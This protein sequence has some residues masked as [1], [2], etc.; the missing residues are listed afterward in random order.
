MDQ[1]EAKHEANLQ[2]RE[3]GRE[4]MIAGLRKSLHAAE[5]EITAWQNATGCETPSD[6]EA[7]A[8]LEA[9][10]LKDRIATLE[11]ELKERSEMCR[12]MTDAA[13]SALKREAEYRSEL[14]AAL[15]RCAK[16]ERELEAAVRRADLGTAQILAI[17]SVIDGDDKGETRDNPRWTP[18]LA[19]ARRLRAENERLRALVKRYEAFLTDD[20]LMSVEESERFL[21]S[22]ERGEST[23]AR[24]GW[25]AASVLRELADELRGLSDSDQWA[26]GSVG[27]VYAAKELDRIADTAGDAEAVERATIERVRCADG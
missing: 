8:T 17:A 14:D 9:T 12:K 15:A 4:E 24:T 1:I 3:R 25:V 16:L 11:A 26:R 22:L 2:E 10:V 23:D 21:D 27:L 7:L 18:T 13:E 5:R 19:H 6:A 20:K